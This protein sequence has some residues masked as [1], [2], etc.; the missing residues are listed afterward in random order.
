MKAE[1][2][3]Q[4]NTEDNPVETGKKED[5]IGD[6]IEPLAERREGITENLRRKH[7]TTT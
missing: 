3:H 4:R 5:K 7:T 1:K 6:R 2:E